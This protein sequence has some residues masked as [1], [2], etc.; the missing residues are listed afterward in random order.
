MKKKIIC[1]YTC[2]ADEE[3]LEI[4]KN[5]IDFN[6]LNSNPFLRLLIVSA[7]A[8]KSFHEGN[9]LYLGCEEK[10]ENLAKKTFMMVK[11]LTDHFEFDE[12]IKI[13]S[14]IVTPKYSEYKIEDVK[15]IID[16]QTNGIYNGLRKLGSKRYMLKAWSREKGLSVDLN[17]IPRGECVYFYSGKC[18]SI[19]FD[20]CNFIAN[21]ANR[22]YIKRFKNEDLMIG[23]LYN[24]LRE[25][26]GNI[27]IRDE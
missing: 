9:F 19:S 3:F 13:D 12:I 5:L 15:G 4:L 14:T 27:F 18:Y 25:N 2:D 11:Y 7:G 8:E 17:V 10:Y 1:L 20:F 24:Q 16:S 26:S 22:R 6:K 23:S 21:Q